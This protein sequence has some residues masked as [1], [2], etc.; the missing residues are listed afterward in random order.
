M[1]LIMD[2]K[3]H[4]GT[5]LNYRFIQ[6]S[7][8]LHASETQ[9]LK[10]QCEQKRTQILTA[11]MLWL[12]NSRL[13]GFT[14]RGNQSMLLETD[15]NLSW[16]YPCPVVCS[17]LH[18]MYQCYD[19]N[20]IPYEG[21]IQLIHPIT[22]DTDPGVNLENC[23]D[24]IENGI[25]SEMDQQDSCYFGT[26]D[27]VQQDG[28]AV[29]W[30]KDVSPA[31]VHSFPGSQDAGMYIGCELNSFWDSIFISVASRN[32][33]KSFSQ[34]LSIYSNNGQDPGS[35][36]FHAPQTDFFVDNMI[37]L[38]YLKDRIMYMFGPVAYVPEHCGKYFS[39]F[40]FL[41][42]FIVVVVIVIRHSKINEGAGASLGCDRTFLSASYNIFLLSI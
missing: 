23:T 4:M 40:L 10:D 38:G 35:F 1:Y 3:M 21:Q 15:G 8:L 18:T 25:Q 19:R 22:R 11:L 9:L 30:P 17:P 41:K 20:S 34:K 13:A 33:L 26:P 32:A 39:N 5:K 28:P 7:R 31:A 27:I 37:L 36:P 24:R 42:V 12:E 16:L 14:L 29:F 2:Y 6:S